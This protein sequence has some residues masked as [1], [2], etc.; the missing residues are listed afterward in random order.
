M[1]ESLPRGGNK[2]RLLELLLACLSSSA[3]TAAVMV[4][5]MKSADR[6]E[7]LRQ[8]EGHIAFRLMGARLFGFKGAEVNADLRG[9]AAFRALE[10][11]RLKSPVI[12]YCKLYPTGPTNRG[13]A[14]LA[15]IANKPQ[16]DAIAISCDRGRT[17][18]QAQI[19]S[20]QQGAD[21]M[22][23]RDNT[24]IFKNV[25]DFGSPAVAQKLSARIAARKVAWVAL[26]ESGRIASNWVHAKI[27]APGK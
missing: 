26:L 2:K 19:P 25:I 23:A 18:V 14:V 21:R 7:R 20:Y 4:S 6:M 3:I 16:A 1:T 27:I 12:W 9:I 10:N 8:Q 15:W 22:Q 24:F 11:G 5:Y 13:S 17:W